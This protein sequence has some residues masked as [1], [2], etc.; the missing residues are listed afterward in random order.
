MKP[1]NYKVAG[2]QKRKDRHVVHLVMIFIQSTQCLPNNDNEAITWFT[3]PSCTMEWFKCW[4]QKEIHW[5]RK[6]LKL[7]LISVFPNGS[8]CVLVIVIVDTAPCINIISSGDRSFASSIT[9]WQWIK[10]FSG[11]ELVSL[12]PERSNVIIWALGNPGIP[13]SHCMWIR[14][15][16]IQ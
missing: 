3:Y 11:M 15:F 1:T 13:C 12:V 10:V 8:H 16:W 14:S 6:R 9:S 2:L 7:L 4:V 5:I